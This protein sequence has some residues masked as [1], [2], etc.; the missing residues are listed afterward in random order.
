TFREAQE[1]LD[2]NLLLGH[3][4]RAANGLDNG[5]RLLDLN[6][7]GYQDIVTAD[8]HSGQTRLWNPAEGHWT[9]T[10][11]PAGGGV[12]F[13]IIRGGQVTALVRNETMA[14]AWTFNGTNWVEDQALL[15]G[16]ELDGKPI[17]T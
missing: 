16:L 11:F 9:T 1:R 7:D 4:L 6:N 15:S 17:L 5:V 8:E 12:R 13:G 14:M 10:S 2:N 3:P